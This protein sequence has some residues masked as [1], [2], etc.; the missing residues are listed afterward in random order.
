MAIRVPSAAVWL[1]GAL[2]AGGSAPSAVSAQGSPDRPAEVPSVDLGAGA[3][4]P[5]AAPTAVEA[6]RHPAPTTSLL[7]LPAET[8]VSPSVDGRSD[9]AAPVPQSSGRGR[10]MA[11]MVGGGA[12]FI[13]GLIIGGTT[14]TIIAAGGVALG[15]YGVILY[16]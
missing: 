6:L 8:L 15:V 12:A 14:G 1:V 10:G 16:F 7:Q 13:G 4:D 11:F 9:A 3:H 5:A 2:I